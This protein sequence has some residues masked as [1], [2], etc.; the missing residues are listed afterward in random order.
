MSF[1]L[2]VFVG[3]FQPFHVAHQRIVD[4]ALDVA[5]KVLILI[6]S[7]YEP[8][9][10]RNPCF[11]EE[12]EAMIRAC[13]TAEDNK[14]IICKPMRD[15]RY[16]DT[17]WVTHVQKAVYDIPGAADMDIT[18]IGLQKQGS[19]YFPS[20]FPQWAHTP[21]H[22]DLSTTG[23]A[24]RKHMFSGGDM[25][26]LKGHV[27][28]ALLPSLHAFVASSPG[29]GLKQE[30]DFIELYK[31]GWENAPFEPTHV[32]VDTV[33]VQSGHVL[34]VKR[35]AQPGKGLFALPGG[36]IQPTETLLN[37]AIRK[38]K[39]ETQI[40]VPV[41]VLFG[42]VKNQEVFDAPFR[43]MRGRTITHAFH[44]V[45]R[46]EPELPKIKGGGET[47]NCFWLPLA[48][49]DSSTLF[50]DHYYIIQKMLGMA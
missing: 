39:E 30:Y 42:S 4:Q 25:Q 28:D 20:L 49:L 23:T 35:G 47:A 48:Q 7:C 38:L 31:K 36:F 32:T 21:V 2:A 41:P 22:H 17:L 44:I 15:I 5:E 9:S 27:P 16:S 33:V 12:R 14:R 10:L 1:D 45:L 26:R 29:E 8:R 3:R 50:E 11:F 37:A 46:D 34:L 43:S 40:K 18:L 19:G 6:G 13:Y 24:I